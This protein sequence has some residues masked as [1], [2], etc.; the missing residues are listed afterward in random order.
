MAVRRRYPIRFFV[1]VVVLAY[2]LSALILGGE[3]WVLGI[4]LVPLGAW[5]S[6][7]GWKIAE[8]RSPQG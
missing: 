2:G 8:A 5:L 4:V 7:S 1:G 6:W 3:G